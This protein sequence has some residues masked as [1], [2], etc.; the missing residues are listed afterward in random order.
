MKILSNIL[1][2]AGIIVDNYVAIG[3]NSPYAGYNIDSR[4][5]H[6]FGNTS[7]EVYHYFQSSSV[8]GGS[9]LSVY[10]NN[11]SANSARSQI[12]LADTAASVPTRFGLGVY[13]GATPY[14]YLD[15][16]SKLVINNAS[17][18]NVI[19]G[20]TVDSGQ[21]FQVYGSTLVAGDLTITNAN[22]ATVNLGLIQKLTADSGT[23]VYKFWNGSGGGWSFEWYN[24]GSVAMTLNTA[25]QLVLSNLAG[26]GNR[27]VVADSS[28]V[29]STQAISGL[30]IGGTAGQI[31]SKIDATN[32]NTQWI[33]NYSNQ[34]KHEVK[35]G[36]SMSVG[37]PVYVSS[38]NGTNMIV[39]K[40]SNAFEATSSKVMGLVE[41]GGILNDIVKVVTEG[42]IAGLDT[43]TATAGDPVWLG[44]A[45]N[46]IF[47]AA[48]RP[49]APAHLV[50]LGVVTRV[51][52]NNGEIFVSVQNGFEMSEL[53]DYDVTGLANNY[54]I[55]YESSSSLYKPKSIATLL[56]YTPANDSNVVHLSGTETISGQKTFSALTTI[57]DSTQTATFIEGKASGVLYGGM[58]F[59]LYMQF[60]AYAAATGGYLWKN[61][62]GDNVMALSQA[63]ALT[64]TNLAGSG[65]RM[66]VADA[67]GVLTTQAIPSGGTSASTRTIQKFTSTASQTTFTITGGYTVGMV[68]VFLNG[69]KIDNATD[70][71]ATNGTTVVLTEA[72]ASGQTVEVYKYGSQ[73]I[74]NNGLRQTTLFSATAG[75]TSFTVSYSV[76]LVDVFYNGSKLD[77][78]EYTATNGTSIVLGTACAVNDKVE[79]IAYSYNVSGFTGVGGSGTANYIPKWTASG[80]LGNSLIYDN[81]SNAIGFGTASPISTTGY[82]FTTIDGVSGSGY[83]TRVNGTTALYS[84]SNATESRLAEQRNLPLIFETNGTERLRINSNGQVLIGVNSNSADTSL[85]TI[86]QASTSFTN[87]IY[88]ERGGERNGYFMYIGGALDALTFRRNYFGTQSDVMS[89]TRDGWVGVGTSSPSN[90]G[91]GG[92]NNILEVQNSGTTANAQSHLIISSGATT[93]TGALGSLTFALPN[94]SAANKRAAIIYSD[95][96]ANSSSAVYANLIFGTSNGSGATARMTITSAGNVGIAGT[97]GLGRLQVWGENQ[98]SANFAMYVYNSGGFGLFGIRNDGATFLSSFTYNNTVSGGVRTLYIDS[99]NALGGISSIR[100]SKTNIESVSNIEWIYK[101]N[102]V[103]FNYRKKDNSGNYTNDYYNEATYGLIAEE[104]APIADFLINYNDKQDGTKEMVGIEYSRL[105]TPLLKAV[106]SDDKKLTAH[107]LRIQQLEQEVITL[108]SQIG[109]N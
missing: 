19:I 51:S 81:S 7:T 47:G 21:K 39:S 50:Y 4:G 93:N 24:N 1:L 88:L 32:Y 62:A 103:S 55:A 72:L 109:S 41:T 56:G 69:V 9:A 101:L 76:G 75:Q 52:A 84:Y 79:V 87:G 91:H 30:P 92:T 98:S 23:G 29:L 60:N 83:I 77:S 42:L 53:H 82:M 73:F 14:A 15:S 90:Y 68:D 25:N 43:S 66:V 44:T 78:S 40:A 45:G 104:T 65:D 5:S 95:I 94:S 13:T 59:S 22:N 80:T 86:K 67:N 37:T 57:F 108:K 85:L 70:F 71:T 2:K 12:M 102:P 89:L 3:T 34:V 38:S 97:A 58:S 35:L 27:M 48:N 8:N 17:G 16:A 20:N 28:G 63:G 61:G 36:E 31:L 10:A 26:T 74:V 11:T 46:L 106:Q 99:T 6:N 18:A 107:E 33:D 64:V 49:Y 54:V 100:A 96:T 105:I